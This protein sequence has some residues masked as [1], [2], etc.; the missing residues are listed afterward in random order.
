MGSVGQNCYVTANLHSDL[1]QEIR[2]F[3]VAVSRHHTYNADARQAEKVLPVTRL[4][5]VLCESLE[6]EGAAAFTVNLPLFVLILRCTCKFNR[7]CVVTSVDVS[8]VAVETLS[9]PNI[10]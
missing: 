2:L 7:I 5:V 10:D 8:F 6:G 3:L 9:R 4:T 1:T